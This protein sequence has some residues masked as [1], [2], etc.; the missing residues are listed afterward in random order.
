LTLLALAF[1]VLAPRY[2]RAQMT[3]AGSAL[4]KADFTLQLEQDTD[5]SQD[6]TNWVPLLENQ[7]EAL[8]ALNQAHCECGENARLRLIVKLAASAG[9]NANPPLIRSTGQIRVVAGTSACVSGDLPTRNAATCVDLGAA[10][11]VATLAGTRQG[12]VEFTVRNLFQARAA[13]RGDAGATDVCNVDQFEQFIWLFVN[14]DRN[15]E[16]DLTGDQAPSRKVLLDGQAPPAPSVNAPG[17]GEGR[18]NL[19]WET[20]TAPADLNRYVLFC[21]QDGKPAR[22]KPPTSSK[23]YKTAQ[24]VCQAAGPADPIAARNVMYDCGS[25]GAQSTSASI[26]GLMNG[27]PYRVGVAAVDRN[28]NAS[29]ITMIVVG[30]PV[31]TEDFFERYRAAGGSDDG[32]FCAFGRRGRAGALGSFAL[33]LVATALVLRRRRGGRS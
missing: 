5:P 16:P 32:G 22:T 6:G 4:T 25:V 10:L 9:T 1:L 31:P 3:G 7:P 15:D 26:S 18:L 20:G 28:G 13:A 21:S 24:A 14:A 2:A 29:P 23:E 8:L 12:V 27:L 30:T 17:A 11:D 19:S 33:M